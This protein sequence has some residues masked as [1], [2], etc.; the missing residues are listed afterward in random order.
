MNSLKLNISTGIARKH[1]NKSIFLVFVLTCT[2]VLGGCSSSSSRHENYSQL[3]LDISSEANSFFNKY[4]ITVSLD[5]TEIGLIENG[6]EFSHSVEVVRG[7][8]T[9]EFCKS[10]SKKPKCEKTITVT[11]DTSYSCKL[12]HGG[13]AIKITNESIN[14]VVSETTDKE[15][16]TFETSESSV[17]ESA[18]TVG[19]VPVAIIETEN[20]TLESTTVESTTVETTTETIPTVVSE[21]ITGIS[22]KVKD[23]VEIAE[24]CPP[25]SGSIFVKAI[26]KKAISISDVI[27]VSENP[28]IATIKYMGL[29]SD[30]FY[31]FIYPIAVGETNVYAKTSDGVVISDPVRVIVNEY[32]ELD[33]IWITENCTLDIG[34]FVELEYEITPKDASERKLTWSS[35]D[36]S[37]VTVSDTG[38]I[39]G[40]KFG[41]AE[42]TATTTNGLS[43]TCNV[44]VATHQREMK[45]KVSRSYNMGDYIGD[46]WYHVAQ[47]NGEYAK[48]TKYTITVGDTI[49]FYCESTEDDNIPDVGYN[50]YT[51]TVTEDDLINGFSVDVYVYIKENRGKNAGKEACFIT[52]FSFTP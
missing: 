14:T 2:L 8:H 41:K 16:E 13:F 4:T 47:I 7:E 38:R 18:E 46:E 39:K 32:V 36:T 51:Y 3:F 28:E 11:E 29:V 48:E 19:I 35:S 31:Y 9:L 43:A 5:G 44:T 30:Q 49:D 15:T 52:T 27:F 17:I 1:I 33:S 45:L 10:G 40:V 24:G 26:D 42:V 6:E 50:T 21:N 37:V 12:S 20:T 34:E 22:F 25:F 23:D